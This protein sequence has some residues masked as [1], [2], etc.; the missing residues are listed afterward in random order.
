VK[1]AGK[2]SVT[3]SKPRPTGKTAPQVRK[4]TGTRLTKPKLLQA[5]AEFKGNL[6]VIAQN[7]NVTRQT[8]YNHIH[9]DEEI[10]QAVEAAREAATDFVENSL[11][12][13]ALRGDTTAMIFWLKCRGRDRGWIEHRDY[14][15]PSAETP[16]ETAFREA[17]EKIYKQGARKLRL[18][19]DKD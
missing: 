18:D 5:V 9:G 19:E 4:S 7:L 17:A 10:G 11:Y 3:K 14:V 13:K 1:R 6:A 15:P 8:I 2:K 16:E 12:A